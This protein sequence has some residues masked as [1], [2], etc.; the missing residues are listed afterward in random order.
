MKLTK[1]ERILE[2]SLDEGTEWKSRGKKG[3]EKFKKL[4]QKSVSSLRKESRVNIRMAS[5]DIA[6]IR[7]VARQ[8]G[9]PYQTLMSSILHKFLTGQLVEKKLLEAVKQAVRR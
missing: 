9:L 4:A 1:Q 6:R 7:E 3:N 8:E 5:E 2:Q